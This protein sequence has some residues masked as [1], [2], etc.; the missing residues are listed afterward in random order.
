[1][2]I[3]TAIMRI[4]DYIDGKIDCIEEL[5]Q[6]RLPF[7]SEGNYHLRWRKYSQIS[8]PHTVKYFMS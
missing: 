7:D 2:R 1:M 8:I 5:E 6:E 3:D 4:N